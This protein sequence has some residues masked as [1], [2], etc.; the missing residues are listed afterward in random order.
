MFKHQTDIK[1]A[2][3]ALQSSGSLD[4]P[5]QVAILFQ[6][7]E[8]F[9]PLSERLASFD[10]MYLLNKYFD[11]AGNIVMKNGGEINNY[12]GDAFLAIFGL[13]GEG[14]TFRAVKAGLELQSELQNFANTV[15]E[16]FDEEFR[17][18]IGIHFGEAIIGMLGCR[19]TERLCHR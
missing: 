17:I 13:D 4:R 18:R 5:K 6:D 16:N 7:I 10:V 9:T 8:D 11:F 3:A 15:E 12:I 1:F 2:Q 19:G 14:Q